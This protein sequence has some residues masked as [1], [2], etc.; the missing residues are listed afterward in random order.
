M[1]LFGH[2]ATDFVSH[3]PAQRRFAS[4]E[5]HYHRVR[6]FAQQPE[7]PLLQ[8][9]LQPHLTD[10]DPHS[11]AQAPSGVSAAMTVTGP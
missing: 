6:I 1:V 9:L 5:G 11:A 3:A 2:Q 4:A 10:L 7:D 8:A